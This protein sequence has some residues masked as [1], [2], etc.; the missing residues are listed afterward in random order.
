MDRPTMTPLPLPLSEKARRT[1]DSPIN[2]L[3]AAKLANPDLINLAAGLVDDQTLPVA[4]CRAITQRILSD[5]SRGRRALQYGT[6]IGLRPLRVALLSHLE[7]LEGRSAASMNLTAD[8]ILVSTGSQQALY[9]IA[10]C[11]LNPGDIV[12]TANPSYFVFTGA[13]ASLGAD[14][15]CV[16]MD[17]HGMDVSAAAE[18]I[19]ELERDGVLSRVKFFYTPSYFDNPTGLSLSEPRRRQFVDLAKRASDRARHR[20]LI[21]E[22]AAYRELR[23]DGPALPSIKSFDPDNAY[24]ILTQTFSKPFAPGIKLGYT[25]MPPDLLEHVLKDKGSHDFGSANITQEIALEAMTSGSYLAHLEVLKANYRAKR[26]AMLAALDKHLSGESQI[27]NLKSR[28]HWTHPHGGLYVWLTLPKSIDTSRQGPLYPKCLQTGVL[29]VPGV[30]CFH[31]DPHTRRC[32]TNHIRL[33]FGQVP[34]HDVEPG[35]A[36][37]AQAIKA[38]LE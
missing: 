23:Y 34:L 29:Y 8:N 33:S 22:D 25:A 35:I 21:L 3:I 19:D 38:L 7:K 2:A 20:I 24:T 18:L 32:P 36:R 27:S 26:D 10:D 1:E 15:R 4:E 13:L 14:V 12:I 11:L 5:E 17:D 30:Y 6:T 16:P 37:L 31:V 9:L 28:I